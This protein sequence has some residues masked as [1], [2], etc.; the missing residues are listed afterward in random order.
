MRGP[1]TRPDPRSRP[2]GTGQNMGRRWDD[3]VAGAI[4]DE[5]AV[6]A[7]WVGNLGWRVV[8][9]KKALG[10]SWEKA[11][12]EVYEEL[13]APELLQVLDSALG[14]WLAV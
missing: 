10:Q 2:R 9:H 4:A 5:F 8:I 7:R 6:S 11:R 1:V 13:D 14:R 3:D 12:V